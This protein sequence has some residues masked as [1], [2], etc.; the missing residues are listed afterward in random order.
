MLGSV[1]LNGYSL[2]SLFQVEHVILQ[3]KQKTIKK[4]W[5]KDNALIHAYRDTLV[6]DFLHFIWIKFKT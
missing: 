5:D 1:V 6:E 4:L 2:I 3:W